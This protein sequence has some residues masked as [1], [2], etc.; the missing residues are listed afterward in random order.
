[1]SGRI[2]VE[3]HKTDGEAGPQVICP[4]CRVFQDTRWVFYSGGGSHP[5]QYVLDYI[6]HFGLDQSMLCD[7]SETHVKNESGRILTLEL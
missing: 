3:T 6:P 2:I 5:A 1:M 4:I 7:G